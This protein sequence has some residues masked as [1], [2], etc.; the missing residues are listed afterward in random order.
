MTEQ[1]LDL[2]MRNVL[3]DAIALDESIVHSY[4]LTLRKI[5]NLPLMR[6]LG[7]TIFCT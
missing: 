7:K 6:L 3:L 1:E 5:C 4:G 2:F